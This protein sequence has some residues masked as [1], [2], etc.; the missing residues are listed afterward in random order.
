MLCIYISIWLIG[1]YGFYS[2]GSA[3]AP[4]TCLVQGVHIIGGPMVVLGIK[5]VRIVPVPLS[6]PSILNP[7][8]ASGLGPWGTT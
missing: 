4:P 5:G 7:S 3:C 8:A 6:F 2:S 1:V